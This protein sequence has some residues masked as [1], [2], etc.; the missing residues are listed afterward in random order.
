MNNNKQKNSSLSFRF[1]FFEK[2]LPKRTSANK[3]AS[4]LLLQRKLE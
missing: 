4:V 3:L 1:Q 2:P